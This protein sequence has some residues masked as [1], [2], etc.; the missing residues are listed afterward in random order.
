MLANTILC[1]CVCVGKIAKHA[2][3]RALMGQND[4][5]WKTENKKTCWKVH[6][7][8]IEVCSTSF[9][10][11]RPL[12]TRAAPQFVRAYFASLPKYD[13]RTVASKK[14]PFFM[15]P[16]E[17][18]RCNARKITP[19]VE[20]NASQCWVLRRKWVWQ[21]VSFGRIYLDSHIRDYIFCSSLRRRRFSS[22][23]FDLITL[24]RIVMVY[25]DL[26]IAH[27]NQCSVSVSHEPLPFP[28]SQQPLMSRSAVNILWD[29]GSNDTRQQSAEVVAAT[30]LWQKLT[31]HQR[32]TN[33][34]FAHQKKASVAW[35][36][37]DT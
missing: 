12:Y 26:F 37:S 21:F 29:A 32:T 23:L 20:R 17:K 22:I 27:G 16:F 19:N 28:T 8:E 5:K 9:H 31:G 30:P 24:W 15:L 13:T 1:V 4:N 11:F 6:E 34:A 33:G 2:Q 3:G 10:H 35:F 14:F 18:R 7:L 25:R 36:K